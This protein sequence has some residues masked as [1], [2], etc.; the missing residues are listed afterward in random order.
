MGG[1]TRRRTCFHS[2]SWN[3]GKVYTLL[4]KSSQYT[5]TILEMPHL[6]CAWRFILTLLRACSCAAR[7]QEGMGAQRQERGGGAF[8]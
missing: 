2:G 7:A 4:R 8:G 5:R 3:H 6:S 1:R